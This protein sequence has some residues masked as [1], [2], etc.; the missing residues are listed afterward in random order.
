MFK[1]P[2]YNKEPRDKEKFTE[3]FDKFYSNFT[4]VYDIAV[5]RLPVWKTW[6]RQS[7]PHI[8]GP[9]VL[10]VSFGT[11]YLLTQ[12]AHRFETF[13]IDYNGDMVE[14]AKK[15]LLKKNISASII[16]GSVESLPYEDEYFDSLVNTMAFSGYPDGEKALSEMIRVLK[17]GGKLILIDI[18]YPKNRNSAGMVMTRFWASTGD[19]IRNMDEL[20]KEFKIS[21]KD[22]EIGGFGSVHLYLARREE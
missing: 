1:E 6:I 19:I 4:A 8:Q 18:N 17:V 22:I 14:T 9:R 12:Y 13:G 16:H 3:E 5:K 7:I 10:E 15:N 20:F 11:G 2:K 21:Y